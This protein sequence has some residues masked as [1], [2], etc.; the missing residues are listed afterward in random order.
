MDASDVAFLRSAAGQALLDAARSTRGQP[1]HQR[2]R[3]L[4]RLDPRFARVVLTQDA[5]RERAAGSVP[6][7]DELLFEREAL[8]QATAWPVATE[9]ASRWHLTEDQ[10]L[11]DLGAGLGVD[12][13]A[14]AKAGRRVLAVE[15]DPVRCALLEANAETLGVSDRV[16]VM[17]ADLGDGVP[18]AAA[19]LLDPDRRADANTRGNRDVTTFAPAADRWPTLLASYSAAMVKVP[20]SPRGLPHATGPFEVVSL[21]G[22]ARERRLFVGEWGSPA[23]RRALALPTGASIEGHGVGGPTPRKPAVGDALLDM[24]ASVHHAGLAGDLAVRDGL[25]PINARASYLLGDAPV[26]SSPGTWL[27]VEAVLPVQA[28]ALNAWL[29]ANDVGTL[30]LRKRGIET[31]VADWRKKLRPRGARTATL[32]LTCGPDARWL[33]LG[34]RD[35]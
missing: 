23:P 4:R 19:A 24:D 34:C 26:A 18:E 7:A 30:T 16:V 12:A 15:R 33:A 25:R 8:E 29:R 22:R 2:H 13:L 17:H 5:L 31:R 32:V 20:P 3:T 11:A 14:A 1:P 9:R 6:A 27:H 10:V 35:A 21:R 28:K